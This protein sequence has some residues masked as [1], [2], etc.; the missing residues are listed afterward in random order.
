MSGGY[1][2]SHTL[3]EILTN[4][5]FA[6]I[7][8]QFK[9]KELESGGISVTRKSIYKQVQ[10]LARIGA[11]PHY[12]KMEIVALED[13]ITISGELTTDIDS[14]FDS[15]Y[16][17]IKAS[18]TALAQS[19]NNSDLLRSALKYTLTEAQK[20]GKKPT[21]Y[22]KEGQFQNIK[23]LPIESKRAFVS[24]VLANLWYGDDFKKMQKQYK[25][26]EDPRYEINKYKWQMKVGEI[27]YAYGRGEEFTDWNR[28]NIL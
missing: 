13:K 28:R 5:D 27:I 25:I 10:A 3:E 19:A 16:N 9:V 22:L 21:L 12:K 2:K 20:T 17:S 8:P 11:K 15:V 26:N 23:N 14:A 6:D 24:D 18:Q 4:P 7:L 1:T